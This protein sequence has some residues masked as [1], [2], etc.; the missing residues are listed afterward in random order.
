MYPFRTCL[1][2]LV[3][4]L[5]EDT[6]V[7]DDLVQAFEV[8][9][10]LHLQVGGFTILVLAGWFAA[11][12]FVE[13]RAAVAARYIDRR[14]ESHAGGFEDMAAQGTQ[15]LHHLRRGRVVNMFVRSRLATHKLTQCKMLGQLHGGYCSCALRH[16]S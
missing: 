16:F 2:G 4:Q 14:T 5:V 11:D 9:H 7:F 15:V 13:C 6:M 3:E 12:G 1:V 10:A 8:A